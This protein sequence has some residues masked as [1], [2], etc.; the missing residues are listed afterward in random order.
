MSGEEIIEKLK[1]IKELVNDDCPKMA[2]ER[3]DYLI[4]DIFMYKTNSL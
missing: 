4:D 1:Q 2:S 3:I